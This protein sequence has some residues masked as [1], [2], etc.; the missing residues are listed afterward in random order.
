M[1]YIRALVPFFVGETFPISAL[2]CSD[3]SLVIY[4][5]VVAH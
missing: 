5:V 2:L 4:A 1:Q 3:N